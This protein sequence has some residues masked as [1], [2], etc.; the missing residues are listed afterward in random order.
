[1]IPLRTCAH[2]RELERDLAN[3]LGKPYAAVIAR[4]GSIRHTRQSLT[5]RL[6]A[7]K[8]VSARNNGLEDG[9]L[10]A[11]TEINKLTGLA[12]YRAEHNAY[13][14]IARMAAA[15]AL[16]EDEFLTHPDWNR[17]GPHE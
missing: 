8:T 9:L 7:D 17:P 2:A 13:L 11:A 12:Q 14:D 15:I 16:D 10:I 1:V 3:R 6:A 4:A 5:P